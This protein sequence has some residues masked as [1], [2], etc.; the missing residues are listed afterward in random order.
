MTDL[1]DHIDP[2]TL[3]CRAGEKEWREAGDVSEFE[4]LLTLRV[5][6]RD[7]NAFGRKSVIIN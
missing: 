3:V 1:Q 5:D 6:C 4:E 2:E 7:T